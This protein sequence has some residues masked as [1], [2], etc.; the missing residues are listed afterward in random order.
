MHAVGVLRLLW[1]QNPAGGHVHP[2]SFEHNLPAIPVET[3]RRL[4]AILV[5]AA[6]AARIRP[7]PVRVWVV[8][9]RVP[10][11]A[12]GAESDAG[13]EQ[14]A[15]CPRSI[16][17]IHTRLLSNAVERLGRVPEVRMLDETPISLIRAEDRVREGLRTFYDE[18]SDPLNRLRA[19]VAAHQSGV[20]H[21]A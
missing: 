20:L 11:E 12:H 13:C 19:G 7:H 8:R 5:V 15:E 14:E 2:L 17:L 21:A 18:R 16:S 10:G 4:A 3:G 1:I 6:R 9:T